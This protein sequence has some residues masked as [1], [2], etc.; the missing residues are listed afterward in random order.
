V[1]EA[2]RAEAE[3][4]R[5]ETADQL[6]TIEEQRSAIR[7]MSVPILPLSRT[8]LVM[9]LVGT[10]DGERLR[11]VQG[12]ALNT[13]ERSSARHLILDVTGV[14]IIDSQVAQGLLGVIQATRLLGAEVILVGIR[15]ELAQTIVGLGLHLE[16]VVTRSTLQ[17]G[18]DYALN[19]S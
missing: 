11:M 1:A 12:Q 5:A 8:A 18:I 9:P 15:P 7:E 4:A 16:G 13:I 14:P 10:L 19:R 3:A 2:A 6:R 17:S